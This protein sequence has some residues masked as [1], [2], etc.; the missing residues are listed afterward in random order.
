MDRSDKQKLKEAKLK[1]RKSLR[2]NGIPNK[3]LNICQT[4]VIKSTSHVKQSNS[5]D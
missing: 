4:R 2:L 1:H 5:S 3:Q